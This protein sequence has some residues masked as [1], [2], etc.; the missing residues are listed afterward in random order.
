MP[1]QLTNSVKGDLHP[2]SAERSDGSLR[3]N[4]WELVC[5]S[6]G[7]GLYKIQ[8]VKMNFS[9]WLH[10]YNGKHTDI[11]LMEDSLVIMVSYQVFLLS[12][13]N[14]VAKTHLCS[15]AVQNQVMAL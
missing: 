7:N 12:V 1:T 4:C 6:V 11:F 9:P 13:F 3:S 10:P 5:Q 15:Q 14:T 2:A 8:C